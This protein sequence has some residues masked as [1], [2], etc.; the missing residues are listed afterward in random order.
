MLSK[1][2]I[3][4]PVESAIQA[5]RKNRP[6]RQGYRCLPELPSQIAKRRSA[7]SAALPPYSRQKTRGA[8]TVVAIAP[9]V[10]AIEITRRPVFEVVAVRTCGAVILP[11]EFTQPVRAGLGTGRRLSI[12]SWPSGRPVVARKYCLRWRIRPISSTQRARRPPPQA[13]A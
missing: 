12:S 10:A 11:V 8:S 1:N 7:N 13:Q 9:G 6:G 5:C 3:V 4:R 2:Q